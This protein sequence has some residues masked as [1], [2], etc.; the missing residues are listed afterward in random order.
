MQGTLCRIC[1]LSWILL[2]KVWSSVMGRC[3]LQCDHDP[4]ENHHI[5]SSY[6]NFRRLK[7]STSSRE[8]PIY[9]ISHR[10]SKQ[11]ELKCK[12]MELI[13][14]HVLVNGH[15]LISPALDSSSSGCPPYQSSLA[16][17]DM[18]RW[19]RPY[20][21]RRWRQEQPLAV[22]EGGCV[23]NPPCLATAASLSGILMLVYVGKF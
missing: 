2:K 9:M 15:S 16:V 11:T 3:Q 20:S 22:H 4:Q 21:H 23:D 7:E 6:C 19:R 10:T 5:S 18:L 1:P 17:G 8:A 14:T 13:W 12:T